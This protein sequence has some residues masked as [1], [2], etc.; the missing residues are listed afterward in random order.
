MKKLSLSRPHALFM[1]G[2]PGSGKT[3]FAKKFSDTFNAP[4]VNGR[5]LAHF[6]ADIK[7][8]E[9]VAELFIDELAKTNQTFIFEGAMDTPTRRAEFARW[10]RKHGYQPLLVWVQTDTPTAM[11]RSL[12]MYDMQKSEYEALAAHFQA[13]GKEENPLVLSGKHTYAT[14]ARVV[15]SRLTQTEQRDA[16]PVP[17]TPT[18]QT[19]STAGRKSIA[20]R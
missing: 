8:A 9:Q 4:Y 12:K 1:I 18:R 15:L 2:L 5:E 17:M 11:K 7:K 3:Y 19:D 20:I 14:Q 16:Q 10:A 13:P 6:T